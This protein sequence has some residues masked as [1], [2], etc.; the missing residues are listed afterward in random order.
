MNKEIISK[1]LLHAV[2]IALSGMLLTICMAIEVRAQGS[3]DGTTPLGLT[4]GSPSGSYALSDFDVVNLYNGSLNFRLPIYQIAGRGGA[5]YAITLQVQK[6]WTVHR[7][8]EPGVGYFYYADGS[9]W[10]ENGVGWILDAGRVDIRT[11]YREQPTGF[12]VE[13]L[14]RVTFTAP[15]GT[16][17]EFRDQLTNGQPKA[18]VSGGF[19]RGTVF[20]TADGTNATFI[21]D[22]DIHE[23]AYGLE[24]AFAD[25][26]IKLKDGTQFRVDDGTITWM[27][28]RNGNKVS[29]GYDPYRRITSVTDSLN[30]LV[31]ISYPSG[32]TGFTQISFKGYGGASRTLKIGQTN[33]ANALRSGYTMLTGSQMF[34]E[35]TS[36]WSVDSIVINYVELPDGRSYQLRYNPYAELARVVLPTGGAVEYDWAAGLTDGAASGVFSYSFPPTEKYIYRRVTERRIY[37]DGGSGSAYESKMTYSRPETTTTNLGYVITEQRNASGTL[38][39]KTQHYFAG[40]PRASFL[41]RPTQ[42]PAWQDGREYKTEVFDTN[43]TTILRRVQNSFAQRTSVSW[44]GGTSDTAPPNDPRTIETI[45]TL[46]P[47]G[48]NLVSKQT[49]G[50]DDYYPFN[51]QN[52]VKEYNF[53]TGAP[54]TLARETR[55]TFVTSSSYTDNSVHLRNLPSQV[56]IHDGGGTERARTVYE[57]DIYVGTNHAGLIDRAN[58]SGLD[59]AFG[60]SYMTRG[61]VTATT[62]Y[63]LVSGSV[64]GSIST[65]AQYDIAGNVVKGIDG[66]GNATEYKFPD[67]FGYPNGEAQTSTDPIE[68]GSVTKTFAYAT[69]VKNAMNQWTYAQFDYYLGRV[70][71]AQDV[72]GIVGSGYYDDLLDRATQV[73]RAVGTGAESHSVFTYDDANRTITTT[74]DL[75]SNNDGLLISKL[76]YDQ[77]GRTIETRQYEGGTNFIA[78]QTQYDA[79]GRAYRISNPFRPWQSESAVWTTKAFD[80][81]GRVISVTTPDNAVSTSSYFG[82]SVTAFDQTAKQRKHVSDALGRLVQVIEAPNDANFN[83][84]TSYDYDVL[85]DL[86]TVTQGAQTRTSVYDSL[87]RLTYTINPE[88]GQVDFQYDNNGNL[89]VKTD[90]RDVSMHLEYDALNRPTRRWFN[91]SGSVSQ[92][93]NNFPA[94]PSG[95]GASSEAKFFYDTQT[96]PQGAP[97]FS[98]GSSIGRLVAEIYGTG[99][100]GNYFAYDELGRQTLKIQQTGSINYPVSATYNVSGALT[101][102]TYPSLHA[103]SNTYDSAGRLSFFTGNLGDGSSRTYATDVNYSVWGGL[104]KEKFDA[105]TAVYHKLHYNIRGQLYDVRASNVNDDLSGELGALVNYY[106]TNWIHGGSGTDNNGNVLMIQTIINS[107]YAE[108][109]YSYDAL[110]RLTAVNEYQNGATQTGSQQYDYDRYGNRTI[111]PASWGIGINTKQFTKSAVNNRL[112]VPSGQAGVMQYD[113]VGNLTN[114]TYTGAGDRTYDAQN[115]IT[116]AWGGNNQAQLYAYD[117]NG[118]RIK[119]TVNGVETW[120]VYGMEGELLAEYA[121]NGGTAT[122]LKE[123]GY[124]NGELLVT[125][126][127]TVWSDDAVPAGAAIAGD[128]ESWNWVSSGPGPLSGS[129]AHQSNIVAGLHQHY[130]YGATAT[131]SVSAGDKLV[132]YVYLDPSNMPSQIMLQWAE[133][134]SW[135]HRAYWGANNLPWGI[136]GTNSRRYMGPL[137]AAG[138]WVKLEVPANLVGLEGLTLHGMAF[139][140]WGGRAT[141]DRAGKTSFEWLVSDHLGTPR[142]MIDQTGSLANVK[143]HDYLPFGEELIA[144][145]GGRSAALGYVSGDGVRQQFTSYERDAESGL[146][147]AGAR[148]YSSNQ[149]RF[150]SVDPL[151]ASASPANPQTFNRYSYV[152]NS[153]LTVIDPSGMFGICPGGGQGGQGGVPL[154]SFSLNDQTNQEQPKK[155]VVNPLEDKVINRRIKQINDNAKPLPAGETPTPTTVVQIEGVPIVLQN[156]TVDLPEPDEDI[157][158]ANG[159]MQPIAIVVLDQGGNIMIDPQLSVTEYVTPENNDAKALYEANLAKTSIGIPKDQQENG[160]FYDLQI[161]GF[162]PSKRPMD[163]QTKQDSV[164]KSG[165]RNLFMVQGNQIRMNDATRSVSFTPG[166]LRKF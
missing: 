165:G 101:A 85:D 40:S 53:G 44:W 104:S 162:D 113:A 55:T 83:Y 60:T 151:M 29:F 99:T 98:R 149:G 87:K 31:T 156:A 160:A 124:R 155:Q 146:D 163:I 122:P 70:V 10:S 1:S 62:K 135:E 47:A 88:N 68:L 112:G 136:D 15:D 65:Y 69:Q 133:G 78:V 37:P 109:R 108:D 91:G 116:S 35:M 114:D 141:W 110:N 117:A 161:R 39:T 73:K 128:G 89:L 152:G 18:P 58:I 38:L 4:P 71:D 164:V 57:Y 119:R 154:G 45:T 137:P 140:M 41:L 166:Q 61:N 16:E 63:L 21:S 81:L 121:A 123:Y 42:Y 115:K 17:Y 67:C 129:A 95:V 54:G 131:L 49:F 24:P 139:S 111:N 107:F 79:L 125:T 12:P 100:N 132:A 30:R 56:S 159:Y 46:E 144:P 3:T 145:A 118:Q 14:T 48:A 43:G 102:M 64:S 5:G 84:L 86:T 97:S 72:N 27:R 138:S 52:N 94:L 9:W 158:V 20:V 127:D 148:F 32:T 8:F 25:G 6:K 19:N 2:S 103:I 77:M 106:S 74:S 23:T 26:Y 142:M 147:F 7:E 22:W 126:A 153:P 82:N 157:E 92:T 150:T 11:G 120:Q 28:D 93:T 13:G 50:Y 34:P 143:R 66:R 51:N 90:D 105:N 134:G 33:L 130:F 36:V 76:L 59:S 80:T 75:N 96:L